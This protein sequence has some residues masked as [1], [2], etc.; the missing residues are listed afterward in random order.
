MDSFFLTYL[1]FY[2]HV[3]RE[4]SR[5][6]RLLLSFTEAI[7]LC[8]PML[9]RVFSI[10]QGGPPGDK[11]CGRAPTNVPMVNSITPDGTLGKEVRPLS[12][13]RI[14]QG[15]TKKLFPAYYNVLLRHDRIWK[16]ISF[17]VMLDTHNQIHISVIVL[18]YMSF[19]A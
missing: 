10:I 6:G 5:N 2:V 19:Y 15:A 1:S 11:V 13:C 12:S 4:A 8:H 14:Q 3:K 9:P 7:E 18:G 16:T 17:M